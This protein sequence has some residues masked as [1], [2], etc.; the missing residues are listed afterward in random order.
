MHR[1]LTEDELDAAIEAMADFTDLR[2][3][4][5]AGHSRGVASS[6]SRPP[7]SCGLPTA[8]VQAPYDEPACVHD[9]GMHGVPASILDK[10]EPLSASESERLRMHP[11]YTQRMLARLETAG[12]ARCHRFPGAASAVTA[13]GT[14]AACRGRRSQVTGAVLAAACAFRAM[15]E[16]RAHRPAMSAKQAKDQ[17]HAE[18]RAGRFD[19]AAVDAVL[20]RR[21]S[22]AARSVAAVRPG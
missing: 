3:A 17:L 4:H 2:S 20:G 6:P 15:T 5:R 16:P 18:V 8:D 13:P 1:G 22:P 11:Y 10:A 14:T 19:A 12:P 7:S 21:W 9:L